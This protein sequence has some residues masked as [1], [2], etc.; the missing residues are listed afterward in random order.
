[1][2]PNQFIFFYSATSYQKHLLI[3]TC[4]CVLFAE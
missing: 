2:Y 3:K 1:M 4:S